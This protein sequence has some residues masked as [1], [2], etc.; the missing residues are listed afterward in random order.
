MTLLLTVD[1]HTVAR[2]NDRL[3]CS[4]AAPSSVVLQPCASCL[5]FLVDPGWYT[6]SYSLL[7]VG[8]QFD[9]TPI[10]LSGEVIGRM[11]TSTFTMTADL[12]RFRSSHDD[13]SLK[14]DK[15]IRCRRPQSYPANSNNLYAEEPSTTLNGYT[16]V[17]NSNYGDYSR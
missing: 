14:R 4:G 17:T 10:T 16:R 5:S 2:S 9:S 8:G 1:E 11:P 15:Y 3:T 6:P 12:R 7:L 13:V